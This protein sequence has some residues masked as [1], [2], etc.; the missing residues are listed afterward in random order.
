MPSLGP[1]IPVTTRPSPSPANQPTTSLTWLPTP[2]QSPTNTTGPSPSPTQQPTFSSTSGPYSRIIFIDRT[3]AHPIAHIVRNGLSDFGPHH[4]LL[5]RPQNTQLPLRF[6]GH[7]PDRLSRT[8]QVLPHYPRSK[9]YLL[10]PGPLLPD[11]S[12]R[13]R[14]DQTLTLTWVPTAGPCMAAITGPY[15]SPYH[16]ITCYPTWVHTPGPSLTPISRGFSIAHTSTYSLSD[17][18]P[19]P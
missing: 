4:S 9:Q 11:H 7:F 16:H 10:R 14:H 3:R 2:G 8:H 13:P 1:S 19:C 6:G 17:L 18:D 12:Q 5:N 15:S